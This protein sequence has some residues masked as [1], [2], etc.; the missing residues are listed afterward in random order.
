MHNAHDYNITIR[1]GVFEDEPCY[2][3]RVRELP[4]I[5]EYGD[6]FEEAYELAIDAIETTAEIMSE[7]GRPMPLPMDIPDDF[8]GR[9][10]LRLPKTLHRRLA[11]DAEEEGVSL[12]A[13]L[14]YV[15]T[16]FSGLVAGA[17]S[18][19]QPASWKRVE[20]SGVV[21]GPKRPSLRVVRQTSINQEV[22]WRETA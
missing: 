1:H 6:T 4:D 13:Y 14:V 2:E 21:L 9:V 8:S 3:A 11:Q 15:L 18:P 12:N 16:H 17:Q 22:E 20:Q 19:G 5:V 7:K 10:T